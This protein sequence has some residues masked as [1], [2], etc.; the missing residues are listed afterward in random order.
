MRQATS[1]V[2]GGMQAHKM[3]LSL[4]MTL[5]MG[6]SGLQARALPPLLNSLISEEPPSNLLDLRA[7][8]AG[9][10]FTEPSI[11]ECQR[12]QTLARKGLSI[13]ELSCTKLAELAA[14]HVISIEKTSI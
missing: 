3:H 4:Q 5:A 13:H 11:A 2:G 14:Y 9:G 8:R 12:S 10:V 7:Q 1:K 6:K